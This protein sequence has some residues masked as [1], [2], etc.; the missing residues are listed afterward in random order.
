MVSEKYEK[1][2]CRLCNKSTNIKNTVDICIGLEEEDEESLIICNKC[3]CDGRCVECNKEIV[4]KNELFYLIDNLKC[5]DTCIICLLNKIGKKDHCQ[6][7]KCLTNK[8]NINN[9]L[10]DNDIK[11]EY[12]ELKKINDINNKKIILLEKKLE[13]KSNIEDNDLYKKIKE[14]NNNLLESNDKLRNNY[15]FL[16]EE[17]NILK[18]KKS[19]LKKTNI[20]KRDD[21]N[22]IYYQNYFKKLLNNNLKPT[23]SISDL[24][25]KTI[26]KKAKDKIK[27]AIRKVNMC[28][29]FIKQLEIKKNYNISIKNLFNK[30]KNNI[31][32]K[33]NIKINDPKNEIEKL[34]SININ[35]KY[36]EIDSRSKLGDLFIKE[37]INNKTELKRFIKINNNMFLNSLINNENKIGRFINFSKRIY[38]LTKYVNI[39]TIIYCKF[40][41]D[42]RDISDEMF[43]NLIIILDKYINNVSSTYK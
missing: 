21:E 25:K 43:L 26:V 31:S 7:C 27:N 2:I 38:K 32:N 6:C 20:L 15:N 14:L 33:I 36:N 1:V 4:D 22:K 42:I 41:N 17:I 16:K 5:I 9:P 23:L 19:S 12:I 11:T 13:L 40:L 34:F 29:N 24:Y 35:S 37:N 3:Y 28:L 39:D 8:E 18:N 10:Y 30:I